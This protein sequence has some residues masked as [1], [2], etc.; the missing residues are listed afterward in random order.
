M[1]RVL[2]LCCLILGCIS[3][4]QQRP[5]LPVGEEV[6][7]QVL[8]DIHLADAMI[9]ENSVRARK[10]SLYVAY[11]GRIF[12]QH[13]ITEE[14]FDESMEIIRRDPEI[15]HG[16]YTGVLDELAKRDAHLKN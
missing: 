9:Q 13:N 10:D 12:A 5:E 14:A 1:S 3:C 6:L 7:I 15:L 11:Y 16:L 8:A 4:Q 2:C